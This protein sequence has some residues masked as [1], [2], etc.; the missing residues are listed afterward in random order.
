MNQIQFGLF[1]LRDGIKS[2]LPSEITPPL[3]AY[4]GTIQV[5]RNRDLGFSDSPPFP[6]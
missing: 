2:K 1:L 5:L 4:F 6:L 3:V